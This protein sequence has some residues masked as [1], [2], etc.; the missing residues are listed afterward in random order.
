M[1]YVVIVLFDNTFSPYVTMTD[2]IIII[3]ATIV[4]RDRRLNRDNHENSKFSHIMVL[5]S[6]RNKN[7]DENKNEGEN[8]NLA[9]SLHLAVFLATLNL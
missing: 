5:G 6:S 4:T 9:Q 3:K 1:L 8:K 7:K 2:I